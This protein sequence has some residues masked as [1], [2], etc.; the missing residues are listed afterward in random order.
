MYSINTKNNIKPSGH[1][2]T[3]MI[4]NDLIFVSAQLAIDPLTGERMFGTV[5]SETE[6]ILEN[7]ELI[8]KEAGCNRK[9]IIKTTVYLTDILLWSSVNEVYCDYFEEHKPA[10][11]VI[12]INELHFGFKVAIEA[13]AA[14]STI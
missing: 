5:C 14:V 6:R 2:S 1:Y 8:L 10:R 3:A 4:H 11:S 7:I 9:N 12:G 13:V